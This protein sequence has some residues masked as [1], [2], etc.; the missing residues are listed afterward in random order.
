M[1][2]QRWTGGETAHNK[3]KKGV[4]VKYIMRQKKKKKITQ[5]I[6]EAI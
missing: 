3:R 6:P 4:D 2:S 5:E 1:K